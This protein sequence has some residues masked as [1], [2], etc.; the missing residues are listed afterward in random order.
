MEC[1]WLVKGGRLVEGGRLVVG[2]ID[3]LWWLLLEVGGGFFGSGSVDGSGCS[4]SVHFFRIWQ[5]SEKNR[6]LIKKSVDIVGVYRIE[7]QIILYN[8]CIGNE[9]HKQAEH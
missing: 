7:S 9:F 4:K 3:D 2:G 1:G 6:I 8:T 5:L